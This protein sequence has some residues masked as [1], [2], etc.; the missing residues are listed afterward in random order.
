[1]ASLEIFLIILGDLSH[2]ANTSKLTFGPLISN[3]L[4]LHRGI[5]QLVAHCPLVS[6]L[7]EGGEERGTQLQANSLSCLIHIRSTSHSKASHSQ[8]SPLLLQATESAPNPLAFSS[9]NQKPAHCTPCSKGHLSRS[10]IVLLEAPFTTLEMRRSTPLHSPNPTTLT[11]L[12][13]KHFT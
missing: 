6:P 5:P 9:L 4:P 7:G 13:K 11:T 12:S 1:M 2:P 8:P 10:L 3:C